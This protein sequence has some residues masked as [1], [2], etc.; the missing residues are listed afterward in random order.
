M[1]LDQ[2]LRSVLQRESERHEPP[3]PD[4][5]ALWAGGRARRHRQRVVQISVGAV[6]A[7]VVSSALAVA[8]SQ[9]LSGRDEDPAQR[10][11]PLPTI[12]GPTPWPT[13]KMPAGAPPQIPYCTKA[14]ATSPREI[15]HVN[16]RDL[17]IWCVYHNFPEPRHHTYL[18]HHADR[19]IIESNERGKS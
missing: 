19:T 6:V 11:S 10:P 2:E 8:G 12:E 4:V 17:A 1:N 3:L 14:T 5:G 9:R 18:W 16:G 7:V 13:V 15:L